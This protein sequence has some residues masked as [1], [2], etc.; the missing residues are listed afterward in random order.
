MMGM[1]TILGMPGSDLPNSFSAP[2]PGM[3]VARENGVLKIPNFCQ[4]GESDKNMVEI[5]PYFNNVFESSAFP[6]KSKVKPAESQR[7]VLSKERLFCV[8][9]L[10]KQIPSSSI[11]R[12]KGV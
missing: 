8:S 7:K 1:K 11:V 10:T 4:A 2:A 5:F 3:H 12:E 9:A 6:Y